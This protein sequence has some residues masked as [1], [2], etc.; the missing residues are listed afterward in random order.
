MTQTNR[1]VNISPREPEEFGD[2]KTTLGMKR[3]K[4]GHTQRRSFH[5][6][7]EKE[8]GEG[9]S[10]TRGREKIKSIKKKGWMHTT[11]G[12]KSGR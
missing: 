10:S 1:R 7:R 5:K 9:A 11:Q 4:K 2:K 12:E 6:N 3:G 8:S